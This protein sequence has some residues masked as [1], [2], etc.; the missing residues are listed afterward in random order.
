MLKLT[1]PLLRFIRSDVLPKLKGVSYSLTGPTYM[2]V[3]MSRLLEHL[4][5]NGSSN[6]E[7]YGTYH[8]DVLSKVVNKTNLD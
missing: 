4:I 6:I 8:Y 3:T 5:R 2:E 7:L 1:I